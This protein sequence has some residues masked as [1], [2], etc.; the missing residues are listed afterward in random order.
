[1]NDIRISVSN[2]IGMVSI[3]T[4]N[5]RYTSFKKMYTSGAH[6]VSLEISENLL[7]KEFEIMGICNEITDKIDELQDILSEQTND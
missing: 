4:D 1:M 7:H 2:K 5:V 3:D 6:G